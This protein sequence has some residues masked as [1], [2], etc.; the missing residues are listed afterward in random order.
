MKRV[1]LSFSLMVMLL[2]TLFFVS[3]NAQNGTSTPNWNFNCSDGQYVE[4]IGSG[5]QVPGAPPTILNIPDIASIDSIVT[6]VVFKGAPQNLP[7]SATIMSSAAQV[8]TNSTQI[9]LPNFGSS[10][11]AGVFR[12]T[13]LPASQLQASVAPPSAGSY[14]W[15][16]I[17]YVYRHGSGKAS[18]GVYSSS[19]VLNNVYTITLPLPVTV[20]PKN[21]VVNSILSELNADTNRIVL[22]NVTA[23]GVTVLDSVENPN[24]GKSLSVTDYT[25]VN[26]AGNVT[27]VTLT[28]NS[29][30][31]LPGGKYGDS[32]IPAAN[33]TFDNC[34]CNMT[35]A[36]IPSNV[37]CNGGSDG[38]VDLTVTGGTPPL[39]YV[40][41]N[42]A[43]TEDLTNVSAG[44]YSV[45][46]FDANQCTATATSIIVSEPSA[47]N[48]AVISSTNV[49]INGGSDGTAIAMGSGGTSPYTYLWSNNQSTANATGLSATTYT[50]TV[51]DA[52][53][54]SDMDNV[55]LTQPDPLFI[56]TSHTDVLCNG[57][58]TGAA[59]VVSV[60]GGVS[61]YTY[62]WNTNATTSTIS[63]LSVGAY[64]VTV[65]DVNGASQSATEIV[66]GPLSP[67]SA[68]AIVV[69]ENCFG[70]A[71]GSIDIT[72]AGG[73]PGYTYLWNTGANTQDLIAIPG[74]TY[75]V[76]ITDANGCSI[77][78]TETL[79]EPDTFVVS[80]THV[81]I[82]CNGDA[83][84]SINL[85]VNGGTTPYVFAWSNGMTIQN[86][87]N[88][89]AGPYTVFVTDASLAT[90]CTAQLTVNLTEPTPITIVMES[91]DLSCFGDQ[92]GVATASA[93]GGT[94]GYT[95]LWNTG[96]TGF[97]LNNLGCRDLCSNCYRCKR[98]YA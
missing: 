70:G 56:I 51:T 1:Y 46:V 32:F 59:N 97:Q 69:N 24:L 93:S 74:G 62:L 85:T 48:A 26:V 83:T 21:I 13:M 57:A 45:T 38:G 58:L 84:G 50:V 43:S 49:S 53:G 71:N 5:T 39:N 90:G 91:P 3:A 54:C 25:L 19:V 20:G 60:S 95:Y 77:M 7:T 64:T 11:T 9:I 86:L 52:N 4:I 61:P 72:P 89:T 92:N 75:T 22:V 27:S 17:A 35:L 73:T 10:E 96:A 8:V 42:S 68:T 78:R 37:S 98:M 40:W 63:N 76:T 36:A 2:A 65:T 66:M 33:V 14:T 55:T 18:S 82:L 87:S 23:G 28:Y 41:S 67:V 30:I 44:I 81:D 31:S 47:I 12:T 80:E 94:P 16:F 88:L 79:T 15:A 6:E 29:P 34:P